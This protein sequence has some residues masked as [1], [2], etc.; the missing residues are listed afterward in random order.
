[1]P[2]NFKVL[3]E[4]KEISRTI[5]L[6]WGIFGGVF[7]LMG[8]VLGVLLGCFATDIG[9]LGV[10]AI[11]ASIVGIVGTVLVLRK[12]LYGGIVLIGSAVWLLISIS[13]FGI[14]G[15]VFLGLAGVLAIFRK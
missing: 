10:S 15:A 3:K 11:L 9:P 6:V 13:L 4:D 14:M 12:P 1:M 8:G 7:G 5:E 2:E